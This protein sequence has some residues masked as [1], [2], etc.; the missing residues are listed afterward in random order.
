MRHRLLQTLASVLMP[1]ALASCGS[2]TTPINP[3]KNAPFSGKLADIDAEAIHIGPD[4]RLLNTPEDGASKATDPGVVESFSRRYRNNVTQATVVLGVVR[5]ESPERAR[6]AFDDLFGSVKPP[7]QKT[8]FEGRDAYDAPT[9]PHRYICA[10]QYWVMSSQ[11]PSGDEHITALKQLL[12]QMGL[13][14]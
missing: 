11:T 6:Q 4:W 10:E 12:H 14:R 9:R 2:G 8:P 3:A 7:M 1:I 13:N 5:F